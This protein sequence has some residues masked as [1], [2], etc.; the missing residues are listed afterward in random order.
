[1]SQPVKPSREVQVGDVVTLNLA[2]RIVEIEVIE[3]PEGNVSKA[4]STTLY[5]LIRS[6]DT[7]EELF[8]ELF[9]I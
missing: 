3:I 9:D 8:D 2:N 5:H 4:R 6:E 1:M 7:T